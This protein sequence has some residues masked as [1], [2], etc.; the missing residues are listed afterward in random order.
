LKDLELGK[1]IK[2]TELHRLVA[3]DPT[4]QNLTREEEDKMKRDVLELREQKKV[5]ARP[6]NKSAAQ[7]YRAQLM[8]MNDEARTLLFHLTILLLTFSR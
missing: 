8:Q 3:N 5:G 4:Y 2:S 7:D 6:T 1:K